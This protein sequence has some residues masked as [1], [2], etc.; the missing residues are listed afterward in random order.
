MS[1][2]LDASVLVSFFGNDDLTPRADRFLRQNPG[3]VL[4]SD[5]A[6]AEFGSAVGRRVRM[7]QFSADEA[8]S[9]FSDFD[10]W[11]G[12][13]V[14]QMETTT[15]DIAEANRFLRRLDLTLRTADAINIALARRAGATLA[16]FDARMTECARTLGVTVTAI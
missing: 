1:V 14:D 3:T 7:R 15:G 10:A 13:S 6:A 12:R 8:R 11:A 4:V 9:I 5:L 16:T 2:Y